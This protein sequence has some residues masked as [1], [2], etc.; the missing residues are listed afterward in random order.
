MEV[1]SY[2]KGIWSEKFAK[3]YFM[4]KGYFVLAERYKTPYGEIDLILKRGKKIIFLEVKMRQTIENALESIH[5]RN[6]MRVL[7][8]AKLYLAQNPIYNDYELSFDALAL[9]PYSWP[10]HISNAWGL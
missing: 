4:S 7:D 1:T 3:A 5:K 9:A 6:Q 2:Q 10:R 8:A